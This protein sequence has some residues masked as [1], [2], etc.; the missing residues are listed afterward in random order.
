[1]PLTLPF[2]D[3]LAQ[4][5]TASDGTLRLQGSTADLCAALAAPAH[6]FATVYT[7]NRSEV[8]LV[9]S[10]GPDG[11]LNVSRGADN[12]TARA[13]PANACI[14]ITEVLPGAVCDD[15]APE[16]PCGPFDPVAAIPLGKG[17]RWDL[18]DAA[19]PKLALAP[20]GVVP[21]NISCG[22]INECGQIVSIPANWPA[23][24]LTPFDPCCD[25]SESGGGLDACSVSYVTGSGSGVV[26]ATN[27]CEALD[28]LSDAVGGLSSGV[29]GVTQV[30]AGSCIQVSGTAAAPVV[31][32]A[33]SGIVPGTYAGFQINECG[34]VVSYSPET[35][36]VLQ[37]NGT[38]P[39]VVTFA[40][41]AYAVSV[42][43]AGVGQLGVVELADPAE[44]ANST[45]DVGDD[46][47]ITWEFLQLWAQANG[48]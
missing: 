11:V 41:G 35:G 26:T 20:T 32:V 24:C 39:I 45:P 22:E 46:H 47:V 19:N 44:A 23:S 29:S 28:Q 38:N 33:P 7:L 10:C 2:K 43:T 5:A 8:V 48:I 17:L 12:S 6:A 9:T 14:K 15:E 37:I 27:V 34:Q 16:D 21:T 36:S 1:M 13:W 42:L 18:T 30:T 31:S 40:S 3:N 25:S 4:A